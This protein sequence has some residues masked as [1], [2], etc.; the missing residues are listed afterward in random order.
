MR[1]IYQQPEIWAEA[2]EMESPLLGYSI[3][4]IKTN[5][6]ESSTLGYGGGGNGS[7]RAGESNLWDDEEDNSDWDSL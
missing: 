3:T 4:A 6:G 1:S 7:A 2:L 5:L